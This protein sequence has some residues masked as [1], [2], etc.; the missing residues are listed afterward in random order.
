MP[1]TVLQADQALTKIYKS[2][3]ETSPYSIVCPS[4]VQAR[5]QFIHY[6]SFRSGRL[7]CSACVRASIISLRQERFL[8]WASSSM[9]PWMKIDRAYVHQS[10]CGVCISE[11]S[12]ASTLT[13]LEKW[14]RCQFGTARRKGNQE[15]PKLRVIGSG[16]AAADRFHHF[17][18][19]NFQVGEQQ[20]VWQRHVLSLRLKY[21]CWWTY[22]LG[23]L[24]R[25]R[26][27]GAI[28]NYC[29]A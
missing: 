23:N 21:F 29:L 25:K 28:T 11:F 20:R 7:H 18:T 4:R 3:V 22:R 26:T 16:R 2:A 8:W 19:H 27:W 24:D 17:P 1:E 12:V 9:R 5:H 14:W 13:A 6:W 15:L 10:V